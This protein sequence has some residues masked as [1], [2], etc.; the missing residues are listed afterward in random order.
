MARLQVSELR[1][2]IEKLDDSFEI[3]V[4]VD[5]EGID[6]WKRVHVVEAEA[7]SDGHFLHL[8]AGEDWEWQCSPCAGTGKERDDEGNPRDCSR[9]EG[10]GGDVRAL[11]SRTT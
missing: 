4:T 6:P 1:R 11:L 7:T 10:S 9:C 2:A 5:L 8:Y 3:L